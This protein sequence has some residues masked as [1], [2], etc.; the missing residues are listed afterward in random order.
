[1]AL[2]FLRHGESVA[3]VNG[4]FAGQKD[5]TPLSELGFEQAREA[6]I[7]LK[8]L[9]IQRIIASKLKR[10]HQ[11]AV[12]VADVIGFDPSKIENDESNN[13]VRHGSDN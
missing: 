1:M 11:T 10:T 5:D 4:L 12:E 7:E 3:N 2:Y 8:P 9:G 13:R 6:A